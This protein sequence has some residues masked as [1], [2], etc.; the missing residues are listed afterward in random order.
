MFHSFLF[1]L[2][3]VKPLPCPLAFTFP[4][5]LSIRTLNGHG[6]ITQIC[7]NLTFISDQSL[8]PSS[9]LTAPAFSKFSFNTIYPQHI[10]QCHPIDLIICFIMISFPRHFSPLTDCKHLI[11]PAS[12]G[13][14]PTLVHTF[15][16]YNRTLSV[17]TQ[18]CD[19]PETST[20]IPLF[21]IQYHQTCTATTTDT[22]TTTNTTATIT[23]NTPTTAATTSAAAATTTT[24]TT[25]TTTFF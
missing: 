20:F 21:F 3:G 23:T 4:T 22:T 9:T 11:P 18:K 24:T 12:A 15:S 7:R 25:T 16:I 2:T 6:D 13:S 19:A 5:T 14:K 1:S 8:S 10:P 17:D